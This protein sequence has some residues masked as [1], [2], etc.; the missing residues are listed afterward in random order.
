ML[1]INAAQHNFMRDPADGAGGYTCMLRH[2]VGQQSL[3]N[4]LQGTE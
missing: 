2:I 4:T 3:S 1:H